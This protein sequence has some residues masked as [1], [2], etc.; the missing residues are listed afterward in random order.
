MVEFFFKG[1]GIA[2]QYHIIY[3]YHTLFIRSSHDEHLGSFQT[4]AKMKG[5][6][7]K[8]GGASISFIHCGQD[9]RE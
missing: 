5:A 8:H 6:P 1:E 9:S 7:V 2:E 3:A 4:L